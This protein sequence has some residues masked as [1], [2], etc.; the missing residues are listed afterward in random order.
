MDKLEAVKKDFRN[1]LYLTW[2]FLRLPEPTPIQYNIA[3]WIQNGPRR[4]GVEAFRGVGKSWITGAYATWRLLNDPQIKIEILSASGNLANNLSLFIKQIIDGMEVL[5]HLS[6]RDNQRSS[7]IQFDVAPARESRDPSVKSVG[8]TGQI[9]GTRADLIIADDVETPNTSFTVEAR[10]KLSESV[11]EFD[12]ILKPGGE[13]L[14]LGTPQTEESLYNLLSERGYTF[15]IWPSEYPDKVQKLSYG[16][17]LAPYIST[18]WEDELIGQPTDP[19]RFDSVD[20]EERKAS[21]GRT[22]YNLQFMLDTSLS[23]AL[24]YPLKLSDLIVDSVDKDVAYEKYM[25]AQGPEQDWKNDIPNV[26]FTGDRFYR[27]LGRV[28][29]TIPYTGKVMHIDPSGRGKD[30]TGY[31][32]VNMLNGFLHCPACGGFIGGYE[33]KTLEALANLAKTYGVN[34][35]QIEDNFGNGMFTQLFKPYLRRIHPCRVEDITSS[36]QKELRIIDSL[37]PVLNSHRLIIDPEVLKQDYESVKHYPLESQKSYM[38]AY[39][40]SHLTKDKGSLKHDDRLEA[41]AEAVGYWVLQM[42]QDENQKMEDRQQQLKDEQFEYLMKHTIG[43][44]PPQQ[45]WIKGRMFS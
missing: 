44:T 5:K 33:P 3:D 39:Q 25:Y 40:L 14:Y 12:A 32:I 30:E 45:G 23:D 38:L 26:G 2:D 13:V 11:K 4:R 37:E 42:A 10:E 7:N 34:H 41:L 6:P 31:A 21:Y 35:I 18:K 36:K 24:R 19:R 17:K 22:G 15:R 28:G 27:P 43:W 9:T 8:I 29:D 20:L 16:D 1:F